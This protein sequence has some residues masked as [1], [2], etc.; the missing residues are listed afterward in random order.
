MISH[1]RLLEL[2]VY[3]AET[4]VFTWR[5]ARPGNKAGSVAGCQ[6]RDG[7]NVIRLDGKLYLAHRLAWLYEH[8]EWP[9]AELDHANGIK[10]DDRFCNLRLASHSQNNLNRGARSDNKSG[11]KNIHWDKR[12]RSWC[13]QITG[14]GE[15]KTTRYFHK[16]ADAQAF[17]ANERAARHGEFARNA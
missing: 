5:I 11:L 7:Y 14:G 17:A 2:L 9:I 8:G 1:D 4:G 13:V 16:V 12:T 15:P 3:D 10:G 6:R